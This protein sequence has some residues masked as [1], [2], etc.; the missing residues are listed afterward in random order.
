MKYR[1]EELDDINLMLSWT[2]SVE[3]F[4]T[5]PAEMLWTRSKLTER[6][7]AC[8]MTLN[9]M[10]RKSLIDEH[11][12]QWECMRTKMYLQHDE[13]L[14]TNIH[15]RDS[16]PYVQFIR[17][18]RAQHCPIKDH[19]SAMYLL[20]DLLVHIRHI[21]MHPLFYQESKALRSSYNSFIE[22][23]VGRDDSLRDL[24]RSTVLWRAIKTD[25]TTVYYTVLD[26]HF[27]MLKTKV[28]GALGRLAITLK[29]NDAITRLLLNGLDV[30]SPNML[31]QTLLFCAANRGNVSILDCLLKNGA[32]AKARDDYGRTALHSAVE[33]DK[34][35]NLSYL[36]K[37]EAYE[38][39][40]HKNSIGLSAF[41]MAEKTGKFKM[42]KM[43]HDVGVS[44]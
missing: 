29:T 28:Q 37:T 27:S 41:E 4:A 34:E 20:E 30:E 15:V 19:I 16:Q 33:G 44:I 5:S 26:D 10:T 2:R 35:E 9:D 42:T 8:G 11:Y 7:S 43:F 25:I 14:R 12:V 39:V 21:A 38:L 3:F 36:L 18:L 22:R 23:V 24:A 40:S 1:L 6:K 32:N 13:I 17:L 31:R